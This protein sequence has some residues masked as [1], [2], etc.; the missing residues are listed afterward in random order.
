MKEMTSKK[1]PI[2][3]QSFSKLRQDGYLYIDKTELVYQLVSDSNAFFLS[4]PRRFG[5]SLLLSTIEA[6]FSGQRDLFKGLWIEN[7]WDWS[8]TYP[9][10]RFSFDNI[11]M[12]ELGLEHA[13]ER[14]IEQ[15]AESYKIH[16]VEKGVAPTFKELI[17]KLT[18]QAGR[19]VILIDEYDK[20]IIEHMEPGDMSKAYES[21]KILKSFFSVLK[22]ADE[23]IQFLFITGVS[24]FSQVSIFSD[25]NHLRD[26]TFHPNYTT[27]CG[28]TQSELEA[29]FAPFIAEMPENTLAGMKHWYNGYSWDGKNFVYNPFSVLRFFDTHDFRNYW[30]E[31]GTPTFLINMLKKEFEYDIKVLE[32]DINSFSSYDLDNLD[33]TTLLFQ[34][35]YLT[36]KS[37]TPYRTYLLD[38]PNAEVKDSF[39]HYLLSA[40]AAIPLSETT[41]P[42]V[43]MM[44]FFEKNDIKNVI[45][46]LHSLFRSIPSQIFIGN[47]E[48]YYHSIVHIAFTLL[49]AWTDSEVNSSNG[50]LD[51]VVK[52]PNRIFIFEFK[53]SQTAEEAFQQIIEKDYAAQYRLLNLPITGIGVAFGQKEKGVIGWKAQEI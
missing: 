40:F 37:R 35:G 49:N 24:K 25:L 15:I 9:I 44:R 48:K 39:N 27:I 45:D 6:I 21:R 17:I 36:I 23:Y 8:K 14:R 53:L 30:F 43:D 33:V 29:Y 3:I 20:P 13:L 5:K 4:R 50:R 52:L 46:R 7:Q 51:T 34:T 26:L 16:L 1:L 19:V 2:G 10:I 41:A 31:T 22:S 28:Y 12:R 38:F 42:I 18:A 11:G 32:T 47:E